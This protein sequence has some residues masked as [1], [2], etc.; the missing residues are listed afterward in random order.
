MRAS[1]E[2]AGK[3]LDFVGAVVRELLASNTLLQ[4]GSNAE[5]VETYA[6]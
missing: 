6:C 4:D 2:Y 1:I 3:L 5:G